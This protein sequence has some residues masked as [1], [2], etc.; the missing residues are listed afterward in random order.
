MKKPVVE[1]GE[2]LSGDPRSERRRGKVDGAEVELRAVKEGI[3][4]DVPTFLARLEAL[5]QLSHPSLRMVHGGVV[6][7]DGRPAAVMSLVPWTALHR[8]ARQPVEALVSLGIEVCDALTTLHEAGLVLGQVSPAE[9][10]PGSPA[11][12]D[13]SLAGLAGPTATAQGDVRSLAQV[14]LAAG[15]GSKDASPFESALQRAIADQSTASALSKKLET[16]RA[17]AQARTVSGNHKVVEVVEVVEPEL[18]GHTLSAWKIER[19]LGEGAMARVYLAT[20]TRTGGKV[21]IKVLKQEHLLEAEFVHRFVQEV[22]AVNAIANQH[23]VG[24]SHF[25]DEP[26]ADGRRC[27]YCV[28]EVLEGHALADAINL[29]PF[30]VKRAVSIGQQVARALHAAHE[31]GVVHRDVK[32]ENIFITSKDGKPDFVKV[33][34][35]GVAKLLKPIGDLKLVGTKAGVVV[36]TPEYMAPEQAMGGPADA[37]VDVYATGLVI[38]ELL[39]GAQPFV[40]ETFGKL[41]LEITQKPVPPLPVVT[42]AGDRIPRGL[43][44]VVLRCLEKDPDNRFPTAAALADA[45]APFNGEPRPPVEVDEVALA[46]AVRPSRVPL[47][48]AALVVLVLAAAVGWTFLNPPGTTDAPPPP[49]VTDPVSSPTPPPVPEVP[50]TV[51][52]DINSTP[53]GAQVKRGGEVLGVTPLRVAVPRTETASLSLALA[54][55]VEETREVALSEDVALSVEL[56]PVPVAPSPTKLEVPPKKKKPGK[57]K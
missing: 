4:V 21:A 29:G 52:L 43:A 17:R 49:K 27:V 50:Q 37:R 22:Q 26:L 39:C 20:D 51:W 57:R 6:L 33:L 23:I 44:D 55:Y 2:L 11:V 42:P 16:L 19:V 46:A 36:G 30:T 38:Y 47:I 13:A 56:K 25:G 35:F 28:M 3:A 8:T 15:S 34:D 48:A 32:P 45:L 40:A 53:G 7:E 31:V 5:G 54:N 18:E 9:I 10:F 1:L 14:L 24:V 41:V 12:L